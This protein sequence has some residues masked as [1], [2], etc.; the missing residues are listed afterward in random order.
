MS[1]KTTF[2]RIALV[3]VAALG[4]GVLSVAPSQAKPLTITVTPSATTSTIKTGET[5]TISLIVSGILTA[6]TDSITV[7]GVRTLGTS[8]DVRLSSTTDSV[9]TVISG[10]QFSNTLSLESTT[11]SSGSAVVR[12]KLTADFRAPA[13]KGTYA[14]TFY[15]TTVGSGT[16]IT[17]F[18]WTI[19]VTADSKS[20]NAAQT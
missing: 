20:A 8:G 4:L 17:P 18:V 2:K 3:A 9:T 11:A 10:T 15:T 13:A 14:V 6:N 12:A 7:V 5:A 19:T 1:T 16:D